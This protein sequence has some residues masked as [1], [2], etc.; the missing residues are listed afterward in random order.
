MRHFGDGDHGCGVGLTES[1]MHSSV[2]LLGVIT[3]VPPEA[4]MGDSWRTHVLDAAEVVS[5]G[6]GIA[7]EPFAAAQ[8]DGH[9][10]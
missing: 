2:E 10:H 5:T 4:D 7:E 1:S 3:I 6:A 8:Q 9:D